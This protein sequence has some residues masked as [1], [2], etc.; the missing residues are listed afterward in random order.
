MKIVF[1]TQADDGH[2]EA[3][4]VLCTA[5]SSMYAHFLF[6]ALDTHN[7]GSVSFEVRYVFLIFH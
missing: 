3:D 6:D 7:N 5:D 1:D 2:V 4:C